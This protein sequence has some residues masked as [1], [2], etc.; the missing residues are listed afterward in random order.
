MSEKM[1]EKEVYNRPFRHQTHK[2]QSSSQFNLNLISSS[3]YV[4]VIVGSTNFA[5]AENK[6]RSC[7]FDEFL[8]QF[9]LLWQKYIRRSDL[10]TVSAPS[11]FFL[12]P[13]T[14]SNIL[15][16]TSC[17]PLQEV[18]IRKLKANLYLTEG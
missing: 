18:V 5:R 6:K 3:S 16:Y 1:R 15:G 7:C 13:P 14:P 10:L 11:M 4:S 17:E 9:R 8:E 2:I 12:T